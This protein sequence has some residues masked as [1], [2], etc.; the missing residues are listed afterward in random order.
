MRN[1][2]SA[3][4]PILDPANSLCWFAM[5]AFW[6][7]QWGRLA[8]AATALALGTGALLLFLSHQRRERLVDDFA[9]NAWMWMNASWVISDLGGL[10][11]LRYAALIVAMVGAV[12][13]VMGLVP[14][15]RRRRTFGRVKKLRSYRG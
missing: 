6:L 1:R 12:L 3:L 8:Y 7:A 4:R 2:Y 11:K 9:L 15:R 13:L 10:P 5:D 14:S